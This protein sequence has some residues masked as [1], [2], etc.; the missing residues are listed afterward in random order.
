MEAELGSFKSLENVRLKATYNMKIGERNIEPGE[1][2]A[3]FD[4]IQISNF[5]EIRNIVAARGGFGNRAHVFWE[6]TKEIQFTFTQGVFSKTQFGLLTNAKILKAELD[7]PILITTTEKVETNEESRFYLSKEVYD[8]LFVYDELTGEKYS[9]YYTNNSYIVANHPYT[10]LIITYRYVYNKGATIIHIGERLFN[11]FVELE[12]ITRV[13]DDTS[14]L[15]T[16]GIIRI[17]KLKLMSG[18]SI[19]LGAQANPV[20]GNFQAVGVPVDSRYNSYVMEFDFLNN[21]IDS[22]M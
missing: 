14:G 20:V 4:K 21:D 11:G 7:E 1:T 8:E 15:V 10:N 12:G 2:I 5:N 3:H 18:L 16:T 13:K 6:T 17:P 9:P 19:R 22:D